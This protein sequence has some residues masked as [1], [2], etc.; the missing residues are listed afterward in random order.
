MMF[1]NILP[2]LSEAIGLAV[3][4]LVS[5]PAHE[6]AHALTADY[7]GDDTPRMQG[8]LTLN[9]LAHLDLFGSLLLVVAK[10]GWAKPVMVNEY[11]LM[12]RSR[13]APAIVALAGPFTNLV[14]GI[15]GALPIWMGLVPVPETMP[16]GL[17]LFL[18]LWIFSII[19]FVLFFFNLI[20]LFPLDGE[21]IL[22]HLVSPEWQVKLLN[23]RGRFQTAPLMILVLLTWLRIPVLDWLV[24]WPAG[25]L[26]NL[27]GG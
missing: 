10:I 5:F 26:M 20:P 24:F 2:S 19:N 17:S 21:K 15:L 23:F 1:N 27:F 7:F 14:L 25:Q 11:T 8:R 16:T 22:V 9:P 12:R 6:L 18:V 3:I 4:L 13:H